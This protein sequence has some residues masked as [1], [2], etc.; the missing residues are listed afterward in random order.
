MRDT[1]GCHV[2]TS[3][4]G[5]FKFLCDRVW[6][7]VKGWLHKILSTGGKEVLIKLVAQAIPLFSIACI[8]LPRGLCEHINSLIRQFWWGIKKTNENHVGCHGML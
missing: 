2:G 8:R 6:S 5:T 3:R 4:N 7:K 1:L